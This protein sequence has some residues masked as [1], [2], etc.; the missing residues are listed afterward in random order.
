MSFFFFLPVTECVW[1][2][3]P[4][5][6]NLNMRPKERERERMSHREKRERN[7]EIKIL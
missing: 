4:A 2:K 5:N 7:E 1:Y 3:M 6:S